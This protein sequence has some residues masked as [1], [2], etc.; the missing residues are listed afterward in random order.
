MHSGGAVAHP[1]PRVPRFIRLPAN[2]IAYEA[3]A[4][5]R[6]PL[7]VAGKRST[8]ISEHH[9]ALTRM[10]PFRQVSC[11]QCVGQAR[12]ALLDFAEGLTRSWLG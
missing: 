4:R 9:Q 11:R 3:S 12:V 8:S 2:R 6:G 1:A 10:V 5:R 7:L